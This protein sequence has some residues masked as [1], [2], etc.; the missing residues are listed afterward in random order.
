MRSSLKRRHASPCLMTMA[1]N[2]TSPSGK[3]CELSHCSWEALKLIAQHPLAHSFRTSTIFRSN[4]QFQ[5]FP[6]CC[7]VVSFVALKLVHTD[8]YLTDIIKKFLFY[9]LICFRKFWFQSSFFLVYRGYIPAKEP[10]LN[11]NVDEFKYRNVALRIVHYTISPLKIA[12]KKLL[13]QPTVSWSL[14]S[15]ERNYVEVLLK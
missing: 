15:N 14:Y 12:P 6:C 5:I 2:G 11:I 8:A 1:Q 3:L 4:A 13:V 10:V 9:A 7:K